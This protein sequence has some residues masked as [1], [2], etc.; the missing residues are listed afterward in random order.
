M[1]DSKRCERCGGHFPQAG[2]LVGRCPRCMV[3]LGFESTSG[4]RERASIPLAQEDR[5]VAPVIGSYTV[6]RLIGEG[7]MGA[8]YE[9]EQRLPRRTV[10]LK[11]VK[12]GMADPKSLQRFEQ[13]AEALGR[14]QHPN[15]AQIYEA[16]MA[17][18]GFGP[19]PYF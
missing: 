11:I 16:G 19:Q 17:D 2:V 9:A 1:T 10:A 7:G 15:I 4:F 6:L 12:A 18:T 5:R 8:V 14:L 3:E 13:E